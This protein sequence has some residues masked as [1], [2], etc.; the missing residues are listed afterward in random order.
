MRT[1]L[2]ML[3]VS[4]VFFFSCKKETKEPELTP[5]PPIT[6]T[7][8]V[9][10]DTLGAN[11][12]KINVSTGATFSDISF[13]TSG[14]GYVIATGRG[15]RS[16]DWGTTWSQFGLSIYN[17]INCIVTE[18]DKFFAV[19]S[20]QLLRSINGGISTSTAETPSGASDLYDIFFLNNSNGF[21]L[22]RRQFYATTNGG[23][24]W[25]SIT[26]LNG[27][28]SNMQPIAG[29]FFSNANT[30]WIASDKIYKTNGNINNWIAATSNPTSSKIFTAVF[31]SS[32]SIVYA[33]NQDGCLYKST[34]GGTSFN[35]LRCFQSGGGYY[36][37]H[38]IN[39]LLGYVNAKNIIFKTI[40]GGN[41]WTREVSLDNDDFVE[42]HFVNANNG[43]ACTIKGAV[44]RYKL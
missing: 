27:I 44:L 17:P 13:N 41:N 30:G 35:L 28:P 29:S 5:I 42:L 6:P 16:V 18:D 4:A 33:V 39:D 20:S 14:I 15:F 38:F 22:G 23:N 9:P 8:V 21:L 36:D 43:F 26:P 32:A 10:K 3:T 19:G 7:P 12:Q 25:T 24:T 40:D 2:I 31:A 1:H 37:I 11:W 34:D